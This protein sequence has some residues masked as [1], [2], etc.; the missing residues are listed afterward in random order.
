MINY[1][2]YLFL[3]KKK[4]N[5]LYLF[6]VSSKNRITQ[7]LVLLPVLITVN[8]FLSQNKSASNRTAISPAIIIHPAVVKL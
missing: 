8:D 3:K 2:K 6:N 7:L 5:K 4:K 1:F